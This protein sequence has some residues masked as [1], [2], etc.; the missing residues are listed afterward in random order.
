MSATILRAMVL[1]VFSKQ[2]GSKALPEIV[3][4]YRSSGEVDYI[5][6]ARVPDVAAY[7]RLYQR[8]IARIDMVDVAASFVIEEIKDTTEVPLGYA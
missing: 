8:L 1:A 5:L 4:T 7:D 2:K 6:W 3:G